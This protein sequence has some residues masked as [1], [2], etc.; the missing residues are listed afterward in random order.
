[1]K[2]KLN[3]LINIKKSDKV[4]IVGT[5]ELKQNKLLIKHIS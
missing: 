5:S 2:E 4:I 1:M 3:Y